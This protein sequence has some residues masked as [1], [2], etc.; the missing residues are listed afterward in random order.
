MD[1]DSE[2]EE[3]GKGSEMY[4]ASGHRAG[5]QSGKE[6]GKRERE[7]KL[8]REQELREMSTALGSA[9]QQETVYRD[10]SGKKVDQLSDFVY[11]TAMEAGNKAKLDA[12][13]YEWG[14]GSVQKAADDAKAQ[15]LRDMAD[16]PFARMADDAG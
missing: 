11:K 8:L 3:R 10:R 7:L 16:Q 14:K 13:Q 1:S 15:Q 4:T 9:G 6:F 12:A 5:L 2:E